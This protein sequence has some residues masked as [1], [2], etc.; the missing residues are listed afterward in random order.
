MQ[1]SLI[2]CMSKAPRPGPASP[3]Q[4]PLLYLSAPQLRVRLG[5]QDMGVFHSFLVTSEIRVV[6]TLPSQHHSLNLWFV[7]PA[8]SIPV[9]DLTQ[10]Q[11]TLPLSSSLT[12]HDHFSSNRCL[13]HLPHDLLPF[14]LSCSLSS[15]TSR[16]KYHVSYRYQLPG[17]C[18]TA[19]T[20]A[21]T[22][23]AVLPWPQ[24]IHDSLSTT[25]LRLL[26]QSPRS[27]ILAED[28]AV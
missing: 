12:C 5:H 24:M 19:C 28:R 4:W 22:I 17:L 6:T 14:H 26:R 11:Q 15:T 20:F 21:S 3:Q 25:S 1:R 10:C 16:A 8:S 13:V 7:C 18:R 23:P 27:N 9:F 2:R